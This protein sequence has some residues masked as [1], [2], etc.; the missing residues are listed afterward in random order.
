MDM[1]A[2]GRHTIDLCMVVGVR[3]TGSSNTREI[4][5]MAVMKGVKDCCDVPPGDL[6]CERTHGSC[7]GMT[8]W[9]NVP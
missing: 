9:L 4:H 3:F 6:L 8:R 2:A 1:A 5:D 7:L